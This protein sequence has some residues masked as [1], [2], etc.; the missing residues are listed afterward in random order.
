M[1]VIEDSSVTSEFIEESKLLSK[2]QVYK[3]L[4]KDSILRESNE[5]YGDFVIEKSSTSIGELH[6]V[7][8]KIIESNLIDST[9]RIAVI[10]ARGEL[11]PKIDSLFKI[12]QLIVS[13]TSSNLVFLKE[14]LLEEIAND[15]IAISTLVQQLKTQSD[16]VLMSVS[17]LNSNISTLGIPDANE[18][19]INEIYLRYR[20]EGIDVITQDYENILQVA[21]QCP[22]SGGPSVHKARIFIA[23]VNDSIEYNDGDVCRILEFT[24]CRIVRMILI[25]RN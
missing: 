5:L 4:V 1:M 8:S 15:K 6:Q 2:Q 11:Q 12:N 22:S 10:N 24:K 18:K 3:E 16:A 23:L 20:K 19:L 14:I 17:T 7:E 25:L 13:D 21:I 9:L